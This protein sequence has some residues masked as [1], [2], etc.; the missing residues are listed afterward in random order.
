[1]AQSKTQQKLVIAH[2]GASGYIPEH[3]MESK[4]MAYA[5]GADYIE[6]DIVL[7][8]DNVPIVIHDI[9]LDEVT[10]VSEIFP[11]RSREDG[12]FYLI[13]FSLEEIMKLSV[14]ERIDLLLKNQYSLTDF[15]W[16][17]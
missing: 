15:P 7:T 16:Q 3:T 11:K 1:M 9:F 12:R 4:S 13:D 5:M 10:N 14:N 2:R 6:Q 17:I 8:K